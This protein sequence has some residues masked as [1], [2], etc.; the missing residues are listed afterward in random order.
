MSSR[1]EKTK[2]DLLHDTKLRLGIFQIFSN[3]QT[4]AISI[5]AFSYYFLPQFSNIRVAQS[6][7]FS[8][9]DG[10][11]LA[12]SHLFGSH[13][14]GD[15]GLVALQ[16][17]QSG[18][19]WVNSYTVYSPLVYEFFKAFHFLAV[20]LNYTL[21]VF[22]YISLQVIAT[23]F[24]IWR[25][26]QSAVLKERF[27]LCLLLAVV[28]P[29]FLAA[30]DRGNSVVF[31]IPFLYLYL[32]KPN[33][34]NSSIFL[35]IAIM[36][37]PQCA[38]LTLIP[39]VKGQFRDFIKI[40]LSVVA[41]YCVSFALWDWQ[42]FYKSVSSYLHQVTSYGSG[43]PTGMWPAD[44]SLGKGLLN[45]L[46]LFDFHPATDLVQGTVCLLLLAT[47]TLL[48]FNRSRLDKDKIFFLIFPF[49][50]FGP[51]VSWFYYSTLTVLIISRLPN[52]L[53]LIS[54]NQSKAQNRF[55]RFFVYSTLA[56]TACPIL[57]P[58]GTGKGNL[59]ED[60]A[61]AFWF[62]LTIMNLLKLSPL[63]KQKDLIK[64]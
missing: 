58:L 13:C 5:A 14:F 2:L 56:I 40:V 31:I 43:I 45:I 52:N 26:S 61:P 59:V 38:L 37:R 64:I 63:K 25:E 16:S 55:Y 18:N 54:P 53:D 20:Y 32:V 28:T 46:S 41:M 49:L 50:A 8:A 19:I 10:W 29:G 12:T 24:P 27:K 6:M 17:Q 57:V 36:I 42:T 22:L 44:A 1:R 23:A 11:C 15:F 7:S 9:S 39:L 60:I 30:V 34:K 4:I 51:G 62:V 3:W 21:T 33:S 35:I 48:V 47:I